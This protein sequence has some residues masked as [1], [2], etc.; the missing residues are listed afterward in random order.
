MEGVAWGWEFSGGVAPGGESLEERCELVENRCNVAGT[1]FLGKR[2]MDMQS[3]ARRMT[4]DNPRF[5]TIL[6]GRL[7]LPRR[8]RWWSSVT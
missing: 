2:L 3:Q 4:G 5:V 6:V 1:V 7:R 8:I